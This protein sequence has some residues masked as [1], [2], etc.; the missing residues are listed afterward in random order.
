MATFLGNTAAVVLLLNN[1]AVSSDLNP[2]GRPSNASTDRALAASP[3]VTTAANTDTTPI[4]VE[5]ALAAAGPA[6]RL[7]SFGDFFFERIHVLPKAA[8]Y[9][10]ILSTQVV[11]LEVWNAY[12]ETSQTVTVVTLTGPDGVTITTP[13]VTPIVF[14]PLQS[15]VYAVEIS[16]SGAPRADNTIRF[17]FS[18]IDEPVFRI[19][20]LRLIPFTISPDWATP[21][22]DVYAYMTDVMTARDETEQRQQ[23]RA[24]PNRSLTYVAAALDDRE[25]GLLVSLLWAWQ[26][27]SYGVLLWMDA[28]QLGAD[29]AAASTVLS[30]NTLDMGLSVGDVVILIADAFTWFAAPVDSFDAGSITLAAPTDRD[31]FARN[32]QVIPVL[33]GRCADSVPV[34]RPNNV[35]AVTQIKFDLEVVPS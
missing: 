12:R 23:L 3:M 31:F 29:V 10:F 30:V 20:G 18:G 34:D 11:Q 16:S 5:H 22:E 25:A 19:T 24:I 9:P 33:L 21:L 14:L 13:H 32:T 17:D 6:H 27:R 1:A 2:N 15:R 26:D 28:A 35:V 8:S 4:A 7:S